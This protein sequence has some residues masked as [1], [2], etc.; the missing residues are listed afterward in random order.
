MCAFS[1]WGRPCRPCHTRSFSPRTAGLGPVI[2]VFSGSFA[3]SQGVSSGTVQ[4]VTL[5]GRIGGGFDV[6]VARSL[7]LGV[8]ASYNPALP[9]SEPVGLRDH[10][11]GGQVSVNVGWLFGKRMG[12]QG[13][14]VPSK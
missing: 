14:T 6:L 11:S 5:G 8:D 10:F 9:F 7:S 3:G 13:R 4:R 1:V 12:V 2:G